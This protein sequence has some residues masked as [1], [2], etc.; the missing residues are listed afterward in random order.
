MI[1][2]EM[3]LQS[4]FPANLYILWIWGAFTLPFWVLSFRPVALT[5]VTK[6][7]LEL[8]KTQVI[9]GIAGAALMNAKNLA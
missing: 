5:I 2:D 9:P 7:N 4:Y 8:S 1:E 6:F 3:V